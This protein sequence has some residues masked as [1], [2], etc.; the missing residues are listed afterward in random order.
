MTPS[1]FPR[2]PNYPSHVK[3]PHNL[4][5]PPNRQKSVRPLFHA[6]PHPS[7][8]PRQSARASSPSLLATP[9]RRED[10]T[11]RQV[12]EEVKNHNSRGLMYQPPPTYPPIRPAGIM[13]K[14]RNWNG[15][16][17]CIYRPHPPKPTEPSP[18]NQEISEHVHRMCQVR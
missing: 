14:P 16:Y 3:D 12:K 5:L 18:H 11:K 10:L 4:P 2:P 8:L 6:Q 7:Q 17:E 15:A 1:N 9:T 13:L